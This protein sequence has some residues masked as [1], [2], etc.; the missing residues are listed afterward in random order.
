MKPLRMRDHP[1]DPVC[2]IVATGC[3]EP[4]RAIADRSRR[5]RQARAG[6]EGRWQ[7]AAASSGG[8]AGGEIE[9]DGDD[10][11]GG[12]GQRLRRAAVGGRRDR[13][14]RSNSRP[15]AIST[16]IST[17]PTRLDRAVKTGADQEDAA[18]LAGH[19]RRRP[20]AVPQGPPHRAQPVRRYDDERQHDPPLHDRRR[21]R[22][23]PD[24]R[25]RGRRR[26][27]VLHALVRR[28]VRPHRAPG[29]PPADGQ[30]VQLERRARLPLR[31]GLR[32]V[33]RPRSQAGHV[34]GVLHRRHRRRSERGHPARHEVPR[35]HEPPH[36]AERRR[37][38]ALLPREVAHGQLRHS[39]LRVHRQVRADR[40]RAEHERHRASAPRST[41]TAR[42]STTS[43][44]RSGCRFWLPTSFEYTTFR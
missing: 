29:A 12:G 19:R 1:H 28:A 38:H 26:G 20:Q 7:Q 11:G 44:S 5:Q 30:P 41:P 40:S 10:K 42:S 13:D 9:M 35:L 27:P 39:R 22:V 16:P 23:L 36:P 3:R 25:A 18:V 32:Q 21:A 33:R 8:D 14:G 17:R 37:E 34:G 15:R 6:A 43:C 2:L 4:A 24:R 31:A